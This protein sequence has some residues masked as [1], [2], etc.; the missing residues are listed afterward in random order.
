MKQGTRLLAVFFIPIAVGVVSSSIG[1]IVNVFVEEEL[2]RANAKLMGREMTVEDLDEINVDGTE[3]VEKLE[4]VEFM[5]KT[6]HKV[7]QDLLD[8]LHSQFDKMDADGSGVLNKS[9]IDLMAKRK[10]ALRRR[11]TLAKSKVGN[12]FVFKKREQTPSTFVKKVEQK[13]TQVTPGG[14][15]G[16]AAAEP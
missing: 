6:M 7:D 16:G 1:G 8:D 3:G 12:A 10:L 14:G 15:G 9:D 13:T 2:K 5:L 11:L 4:F